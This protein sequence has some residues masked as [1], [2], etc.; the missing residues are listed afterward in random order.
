MPEETDIR[1]VFRQ[2][3]EQQP[4]IGVGKILL[5]SLLEAPNIFDP[6]ARK[7]PK[8]EVVLALAYVFLMFAVCAAFNC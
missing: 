4:E 1:R 3:L 8:P 7:R 2:V 6:T 5:S